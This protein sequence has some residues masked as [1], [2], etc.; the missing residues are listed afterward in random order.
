MATDLT[1]GYVV[2]HCGKRPNCC[3]PLFETESGSFAATS[4][5]TL[6]P[7]AAAARAAIG[8]DAAFARSR[9]FEPQRLAV[10]RLVPAR[11][12]QS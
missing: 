8:R 12:G 11:E 6:Y 10:L 4:A 7:T 3:V 9:G 5:G 2:F 1:A